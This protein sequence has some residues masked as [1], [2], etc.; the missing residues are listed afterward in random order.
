MADE[1]QGQEKAYQTF[2]PKAKEIAAEALIVFRAD[3]QLALQNTK[4]GLTNVLSQKD[5]LK[6]RFTPEEV[7]TM[8][9]LL[10]VA[11][12]VVFADSQVNT[13]LSRSTGE[14]SEKLAECYKLRRILLTGAQACLYAELLTSDEERELEKIELGQGALD[15]SQDCVDLVAL[16]NK[17]ERLEENTPATKE[18]LQ[19]AAIVGSELVLLLQSAAT[20]RDNIQ[21]EKLKAAVESRARLWTLLT[22]GHELLLQ[23][24]TLLYGTKKV[25]QLVPKLQSREVK[26][27][28]KRE[29]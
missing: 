29:S 3:S 21:P 18:M 10:E 24:G 13:L 19:R 15:A 22:Q 20:P 8:E 5:K 26:P 16:Y 6:G 11:Q 14:I 7:E 4:T 23:A 25:Y 17:T 27:R 12:A 9:T 28:G 2:L 1:L